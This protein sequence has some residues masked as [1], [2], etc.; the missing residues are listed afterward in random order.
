MLGSR[1]KTERPITNA[2]SWVTRNFF[3]TRDTTFAIYVF[4][5]GHVRVTNLTRNRFIELFYERSPNMIVLPFSRCHD[6]SQYSPSSSLPA[7]CKDSAGIFKR[8]SDTSFSFF[9]RFFQP[10]FLIIN[11]RAFVARGKFFRPPRAKFFGT[12]TLCRFFCFV[13]GRGK[14]GRSLL[15]FLLST[16]Q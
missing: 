1:S 13:L 5:E 15:Y 2:S 11:M 16:Q 14:Q 3:I 8:L 7:S 12:L 9:S 4:E 10:H 6:S